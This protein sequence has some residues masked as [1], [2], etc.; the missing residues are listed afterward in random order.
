MKTSIDNLKS[1]IAVM[2]G[3]MNKIENALKRQ[4][5]FE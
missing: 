3:M 5:I 4:S 1:E 2:P